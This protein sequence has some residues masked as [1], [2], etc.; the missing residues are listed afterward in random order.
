MTE[1]L[2]KRAMVNLMATETFSLV[3]VS[4]FSANENL[5]IILGITAFAKE[6][7]NEAKA[8]IN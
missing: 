3:R 7:D 1:E 4:C 8:E 5:L 2:R 6:I